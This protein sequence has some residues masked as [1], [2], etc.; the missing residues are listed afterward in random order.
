[1]SLDLIEKHKN[2]LVRIE[3]LENVILT[4][5]DFGIIEFV[6]EMKFARTQD[7]F[8][9]FFSVLHS[10]ESAISDLWA[11]KRLLQLERGGFLKS[12]RMPEM[13]KRD[14]IYTAT[15]RG[16]RAVMNVFPEKLLCKP[17]LSVDLRTFG[18]DLRVLQ[19]RLMLEAL[20]E[21]KSWIS[22]RQLKS[23]RELSGGFRGSEVPDGIFLTGEGRKIAFELEIARKSKSKYLAKVKRYVA[24]LRN[25]G[26]EKRQ[27][28]SV[29][30]VC[31]NK[32]VSQLLENETRIYGDCF[33]VL[34]FKQFSEKQA[35]KSAHQKS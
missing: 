32:Q 28:E 8:Q 33:R 1:M 4:E 5:R 2:S 15:I 3:E 31:G 34:S 29:L 21:I 6:C 10:G 18:H 12:Y 20:G 27:F 30:Y 23:F 13:Q 14:L 19:C 24:H 22:D 17:M 26:L 9:K 7:L 16:Y 11:R 25:R 35:L